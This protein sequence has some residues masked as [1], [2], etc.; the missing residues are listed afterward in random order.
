MGME[1]GLR[2]FCS[3]K[4]VCL[5]NLLFK[6]LDNEQDVTMWPLHVYVVKYV[7]VLLVPT[8]LLEN[9]E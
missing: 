9:S 1:D 2:E 5:R 4:D 7:N 3:S 8:L 6:S